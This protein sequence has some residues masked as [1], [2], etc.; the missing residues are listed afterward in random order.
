M[1]NSL[2]DI[3]YFI[4]DRRK[5]IVSRYFAQC[6]K[7]TFMRPLVNYNTILYRSQQIS[8]TMCLLRAI[9]GMCRTRGV[10][11][12]NLISLNM[13][14]IRALMDTVY[15]NRNTEVRTQEIKNGRAG[16]NLSFLVTTISN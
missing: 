4:R 2:S 15:R 10:Y 5:V 1:L 6:E 14:L 3:S 16:T 11:L 8:Y 12:R 9:R 7:I 13:T